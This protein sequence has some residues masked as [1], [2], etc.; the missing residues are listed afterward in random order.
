M[1]AAVTRAREAA[2]IPTSSDADRPAP[3]GW[4]ALRLLTTST[5]LF[6]GI[7]VRRSG[8]TMELGRSA[9]MLTSAS[10]GRGGGD[11]AGAGRAQRGTGSSAT[12]AK[13]RSTDS[14]Q[15]PTMRPLWSYGV[16]G[17]DST[18]RKPRLRGSA[19]CSLSDI[20]GW[21]AGVLYPFAGGGRGI[22]RGALWLRRRDAAR[23]ARAGAAAADRR[24]RFPL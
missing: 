14:G 15:R 20:S 1:L 4:A 21:R 12:I 6:G 7:V 8:T 16:D 9:P 2:P 11:G 10:P 18:D 19:A 22:R 17:A 24:R 5:F 13:F 23:P 3:A